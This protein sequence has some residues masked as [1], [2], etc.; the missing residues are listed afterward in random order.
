MSSPLPQ[1]T[2][3]RAGMEHLRAVLGVDWTYFDAADKG[4]DLVKHAMAQVHAVR[5]SALLDVHGGGFLPGEDSVQLPFDWPD[6]EV[7][8][9][10]PFLERNFSSTH[11]LQPGYDPYDDTVTTL[12]EAKQNFTVV[13]Y[14]PGLHPYEYVPLGPVACYHS[15]KAVIEATASS[16]LPSLILEDD[17]DFDVDI[18]E[19]LR[20]V[21]HLLPPDWDIV[22]LGHCWGDEE[23]YPAL[24]SLTPLPAD[25][26]PSRI[27]VHPS[28]RPLCN[29][30]YAVSP[31]GARRLARY[32]NHPPFAYSRAIDQLVKW[33]ILH[34][35]IKSFSIMPFVITQFKLGNY[36]SDL[37]SDVPDLYD[38][39]LTKGILAGEYERK[40]EA[41]LE[42]QAR[43]S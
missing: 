1:R 4:S 34:N 3:R 20:T 17:V 28:H 6:T 24:F 2:D 30:G 25:L 39:R 36:K 42:Q 21:W 27:T 22:F 11:S 26:P 13:R 14:R 23:R 41:D 8:A 35:R 7:D 15:H 18:K 29:H 31:A 19:Q 10:V 12:M 38:W 33:L 16:S 5:K 43:D 37:I 40:Q 9:P 32:L